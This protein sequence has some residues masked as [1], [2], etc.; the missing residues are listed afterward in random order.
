MN[1]PDILSSVTTIFKKV[2]KDEN[3]TLKEEHSAT[4]FEKW[5]SINNMI[6]ISRA[7]KLF[8][9]SID[10]AELIEIR[11]VGD[12]VTLIETKIN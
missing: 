7:E 2:F 12:L 4:D 6:I 1:R 3:L 11:N 10:T 5:D 8:G 9:I